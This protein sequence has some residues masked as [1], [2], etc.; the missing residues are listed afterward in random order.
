M[1]GSVTDDE[2]PELEDWTDGE[3]IADSEEPAEPLPTLEASPDV[4]P[5]SC[6]AGQSVGDGRT[7]WRR[8][9]GHENGMTPDGKVDPAGVLA[10][11]AGL[12]VASAVAACTAA[13][14]AA[15]S[16]GGNEL[17]ASQKRLLARA[18]QGAGSE[19]ESVG[20]LHMTTSVGQTELVPLPD[21]ALPQVASTCQTSCHSPT[22]YSERTLHPSVGASPA[23]RERL[24][25]RQ[26]SCS[27]TRH[28]HTSKPPSLSK[29]PSP[30][31]T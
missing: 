10:I 24:R 18:V 27:T 11:C 9:C 15:G 17:S 20:P 19:D 25:H 5:T 2:P 8:G 4:S 16:S 13:I 23:G 31:R 7:Q 26:C 1:E 3:S 12:G 14:P 21:Q 6:A 29:P 22:R 30:T 28:P